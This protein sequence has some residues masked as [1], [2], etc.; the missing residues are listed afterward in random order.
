MTITPVFCRS[1]FKNK[2][3]Q[4]LLDADIDYLPSPLD[5][6]AMEG[7]DPSNEEKKLTREVSS[8]AP[9]SSLAFK[10][11]TDPFVGQ[12]TYFRVYSGKLSAGDTVLNSTS[13]KKERLGRILRMHANQREEVKQ[14]SAGDI[15]AA[16]GLKSTRTGDT[17]CDGGSPIVLESMSF[18]DPVISIA[19]EPKS[20]SDEEKLSLSLQKL[21]SED[22][23]LR[24]HVDQESGQ[25]IIA[26]MGEL[27]LEVIVDRMKREFNVEANIG[28]PQVAYRE[29]ICKPYTVENKYAKQSGGRGQFAH[30]VMLVEPNEEEGIEFIDQIKGGRIPREFI[31]A[32]KKGVEEA[33]QGGAIAGYPLVNLKITLK[34]GSF[35]EVDSSDMA[36]KICASMALKDAVRNA[37]PALLE[38]VMDV[39]VVVPEDFVGAV[40]GDL[41]S[42]RGKILKS[43]MS[44]GAQVMDANVPLST[45][46]GYATDL[47]SATQGRATYTMQ[48]AHYEKLPKNLAE[49]VIAKAKGGAGS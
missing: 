30:V 47:R 2:G 25:T 44:A 11:M 20:K 4:Q 35:H 34:D 43:D 42:R 3:V 8:D 49:E 27:H 48:F 45:M 16:V 39:E 36:F 26:G 15:C 14:V 29:T 19:I 10:I 40:T 23:S 38:P 24:V 13:G 46:F 28:R 12:L 41:T 32:V 1:A 6:A 9:F 31:P 22:P 17:L 33:A 5:V 37:D 21:C 18:P 7:H